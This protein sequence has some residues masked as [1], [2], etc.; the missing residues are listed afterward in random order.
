MEII[1]KTCRICLS[2]RKFVAGSER[3]NQSICGECWNWF[4]VE[5]NA[6]IHSN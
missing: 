5:K 1:K 3:D 2:V 4:G 6:P